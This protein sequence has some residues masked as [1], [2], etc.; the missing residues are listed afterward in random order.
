MSVAW[1][2]DLTIRLLWEAN[3]Q[4]AF[5]CEYGGEHRIYDE[6]MWYDMRELCEK[7]IK[8]RW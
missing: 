6:Q 2:I 8:T 5:N 7:I 1:S 4:K 3:Y